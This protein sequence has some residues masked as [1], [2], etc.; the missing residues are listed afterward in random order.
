MV[1]KHSQS[2]FGQSTGITIQSSSRT[3]PFIFL[4]CIQKKSDGNWEKPSLGE[5][6]TIK[7]NLDEMVMISE[8]LN[9][10]LDKWSSFHTFNQ[11]KTQIT[12]QWEDQSKNKLKIYIDKYSKML[13]FAQSEIFRRLLEHLLEEK[14]V[15]ATTLNSP[16]DSSKPESIPQSKHES[17]KIKP[18]PMPVVQEFIEYSDK[19]Q[20]EITGTI[21]GETDKAL[22]IKFDPDKQIWIPKSRIH[23]NFKSDNSSDQTFLIESWILKK[24]NLIQT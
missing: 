23:S 16:D 4:K 11:I 14:I 18:K 17:R 9:R 12:F 10:N 24:N 3:D 20:S 7:L 22:L 5:G 21:E 6:K 8:V 13:N 1:D 19:P 15:Y 2:F